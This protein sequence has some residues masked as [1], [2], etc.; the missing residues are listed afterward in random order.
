VSRATFGLDKAEN[1]TSGRE[2]GLSAE[3]MTSTH[4]RN[5]PVVWG[6]R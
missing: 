5:K 3:P 2:N 4:M 6:I 1:G